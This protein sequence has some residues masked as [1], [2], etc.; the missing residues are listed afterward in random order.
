MGVDNLKSSSSVRDA[1][2]MSLLAN[3]W[4]VF[5]FAV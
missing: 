3:I 5:L 2:M 1:H 4:V